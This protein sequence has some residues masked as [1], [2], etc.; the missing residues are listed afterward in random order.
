MGGGGN[1]RYVQNIYNKMSFRRQMRDYT[2]DNRRQ[3]EQQ[4]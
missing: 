3:E 4:V 2:K 1:S